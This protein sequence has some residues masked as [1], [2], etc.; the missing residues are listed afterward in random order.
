[1]YFFSQTD[2]SLYIKLNFVNYTRN[3]DQEAHSL[4]L[5][6]IKYFHINHKTT[7]VDPYLKNGYLNRIW[8]KQTICDSYH[9][10]ILRNIPS[11]TA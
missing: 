9:F 11:E 1:M 3:P 5:A 2:D 4:A 7:A 6:A 8:F 10:V